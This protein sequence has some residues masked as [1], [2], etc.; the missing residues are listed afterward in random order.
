MGKA[1]FSQAAT[2]ENTDNVT[3]FSSLKELLGCNEDNEYDGWGVNCRLSVKP[4]N[5]ANISVDVYNGDA[6]TETLVVNFT[7]LHAQNNGP[8]K[9]TGA[10]TRNANGGVAEEIRTSNITKQSLQNLV[11]QFALRHITSGIKQ[12]TAFNLSNGDNCYSE[13]LASLT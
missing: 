7:F 8:V 13:L 9:L 10:I 5:T 1:Q 11:D 6:V 3:C 2:T 4:D 12:S